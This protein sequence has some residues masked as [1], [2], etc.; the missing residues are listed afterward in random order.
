MKMA[1]MLWWKAHWGGEWWF[2]SQKESM[3]I[4]GRASTLNFLLVLPRPNSK[5]PH[6]RRV[7]N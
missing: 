3:F 2:K 5:N 4:T 6:I 1:A 7:A